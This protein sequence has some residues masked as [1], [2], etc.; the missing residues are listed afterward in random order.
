MK[1]D[2]DRW[3]RTFADRRLPRLPG[4][5]VAPEE[6][7]AAAD[8]RSLCCDPGGP[9]RRVLVTESLDG[10]S[11]R[12][13]RTHDGG[14]LIL[15]RGGYRAVDYQ[16]EAGRK[17]YEWASRRRW[18]WVPAGFAVCGERLGQALGARYECPHGP[19]VAHGLRD[20]RRTAGVTWEGLLAVVGDRV[21]VVSVLHD[22]PVGCSVERALERLGVQG[23]HGAL[24]ATEGCVWRVESATGSVWSAKVVRP[25]YPPMRYH[26][27]VSG[28]RTVYNRCK[29][30]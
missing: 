1:C 19:F 11:V 6:P 4:S 14:I 8:L 17:W 23:K 28:G 5:Q 9:P 10:L 3:P 7:E 22:S 18:D 21:P 27:A 16:C 26:P 29:E 30:D 20:V 25:G 15:V 13:Q 2:D 24:E 12:V